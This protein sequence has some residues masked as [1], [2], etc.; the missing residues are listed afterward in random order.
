M[1]QPGKVAAMGV[2]KYNTDPEFPTSTTLDGRCTFFPAPC[3]VHKLLSKD[4]STFAPISA[5]H[6]A[7]LRQSALG[8]G[9]RINEVPSA[10]AANKQALIVWLFDPGTLMAPDKVL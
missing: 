7:A 8:N 1:L 5:M 3:T 2:R 4:I 10:M 6:R 9:L